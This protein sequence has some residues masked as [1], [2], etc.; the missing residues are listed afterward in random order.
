[1]GVAHLTNREFGS[2]SSGEQ[3]R[4]LLART[5][6]NDPD[7]ILL[8]E[9]SARLDLGGREELVA[10]LG[11]LIGHPQA[12]PLVLVTHHIDEI[13]SGI[14][15]AMLMQAGN[16]MIAGPIEQTLTAQS[17]S[18]CF[19]IALELRRRPSGRFSAWARDQQG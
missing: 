7:V 10:T 17:L 2:L 6:M 19:G 13:P 3:Q 8:D 1:M 9:P 12:P 16:V 15:H 14:T 11:D 5:F 4:V 18:E